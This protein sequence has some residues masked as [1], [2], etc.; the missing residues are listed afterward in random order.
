MTSVQSAR[1]KRIVLPDLS[2]SDV[3]DLL[4]EVPAVAGEQFL[5]AV[6][7]LLVCGLL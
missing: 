4:F 3:G 7:L 1:T 2:S 6:S 5:A